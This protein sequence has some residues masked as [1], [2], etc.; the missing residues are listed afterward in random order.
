MTRIIPIKHYH[1]RE[2]LAAAKSISWKALGIV[3]G[4]LMAGLGLWMAWAWFEAVVKELSGR[5]GP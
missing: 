5:Y 1:R 4:G 3:S 2:R